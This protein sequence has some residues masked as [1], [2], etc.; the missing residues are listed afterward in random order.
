MRII[1]NIITAQIEETMA[2]KLVW[3]RIRIDK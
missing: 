3:W 2:C 1:G